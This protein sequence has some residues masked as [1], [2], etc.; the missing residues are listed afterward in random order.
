MKAR[1]LVCCLLL[2]ATI[3]MSGCYQLGKATGA[4]KRAA[5]QGAQEVK[6]GYRESVHEFKEGYHQGEKE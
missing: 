1:I 3:G 5:K 6:E 4:T 2:F